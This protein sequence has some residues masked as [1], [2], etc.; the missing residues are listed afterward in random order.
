MGTIRM[1]VVVRTYARAVVALAVVGVTLGLSPAQGSAPRATGRI[2]I[3]QAFP[4]A[5]L[6][7]AVDG[8][9]VARDAEVRTVVRP[10][11]LAAGKHEV[12]FTGAD[13]VQPMTTIVDVRAG[14]SSDVVLHRPASIT[15]DPVVNVYRTP[16]RPISP[17]K[18]RVLLAHTATV[19]PADVEVDD[20]VV[21]RNIA[22]GEF[23]EAELPAGAHQ[24]ALLPSG[25]AGK[26]LLGPL[27]LSL[28]PA[29][30]TMVYAVGSP[31]NA[32][33]DVI[34]HTVDVSDDG[35]VAPARI[36]TGSAGLVRFV[37]VHSFH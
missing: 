37:R 9:V 23:A 31:A 14:S 30:A 13:G 34:V 19:A 4:E 20:T 5:T 1:G 2:T 6:D 11:D 12:T 35:S 36:D 27:R 25:V 15:G 32:S 21:F 29:T 26:P 10:L 22:N 16:R 17:G 3:V 7:V 33:M 8:R 28:A 24:V 18:A